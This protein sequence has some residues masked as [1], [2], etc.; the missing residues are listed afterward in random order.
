MWK[1][2]SRPFDALGLD[3]NSSMAYDNYG[4]NLYWVQGKTD[5]AI[6]AYR[7]AIELDPKNYWPCLNLSSALRPGQ[8][9]GGPRGR[10]PGQDARPETRP[11]TQTNRLM[12]G[13][14]G[15]RAVRLPRR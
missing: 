8:V 13:R 5:D 6:A 4:N 1:V 10:T 15:R 14:D 7:R 11:G 9:G 12:D 2:A 3:P